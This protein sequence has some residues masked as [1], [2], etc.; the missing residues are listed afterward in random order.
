MVVIDPG[1]DLIKINFT[2]YLRK[3]YKDI[4]K[5]DKYMLAKIYGKMYFK[6]TDP[7]VIQFEMY[8][9]RRSN[10][11][12][13]LKLKNIVEAIDVINF[14]L[15]ISD[16][17]SGHHSDYYPKWMLKPRS[18]IIRGLIKDSLGLTGTS[19]LSRNGI[20]YEDLEKMHQKIQYS[21]KHGV[22]IYDICAGLSLDPAKDDLFMLRK[23]RING[24][25]IGNID[26][27]EAKKRG[28]IVNYIV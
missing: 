3:F 25:K 4:R 10:V 28:K 17:Y 14:F 18:S 27:Y 24:F 13:V 21:C 2:D 23:R 7:T 8:A 9:D 1:T 19:E 26:Y 6:L 11:V 16:A 5:Y 15:E 20:E 22:H 12:K